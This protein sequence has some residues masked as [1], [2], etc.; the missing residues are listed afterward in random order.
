MALVGVNRYRNGGSGG[1]ERLSLSRRAFLKT[2]GAAGLFAV[3]GNGLLALWD[4]FGE[5]DLTA[6]VEAGSPAVAGVDS[7][8]IG[9]VE[10]TPTLIP[11]VCGMCPFQC[12]VIA[13]VSNGRLLKLEGNFNHSHSL[14]HICPRGSAA[15]KT[16]YDPNR[17]QTPL[18]RVGKDNFE[19]ISWEQ[20]Y[21][22]IGS[23]LQELRAQNGP[24]TLAMV[25]KPGLIDEWETQFMAAF[26]SPNIFSTSSV[27]D[28]A[29]KLACQQTLGSTPL[30]DLA[31]SKYIVMFGSNF[32]ETGYTSDTTALASAK[33]NGAHIVVVDPRLTNTAAYAHE[34]LPVKPGTEGAMMLAMMNVMVKEQLYDAAFVADYVNGFDEFTKFLED[35]TPDWAEI[36]TQLSADSITR[37]ARE[38]AG[39][40]PACAVDAGFQTSGVS[41]FNNTVQTARA[42]LALNA[43]LG[44]IGAKGGLLFP[45]SQGLGKFSP[46]S[47]APVTAQ[48]VD[49]AGSQELLFASTSD[50]VVQRLPEVIL[51]SNPYPL[52][53][54]I[55][56][57]SNPARSLPNTTKV[58]SA[59]QKLDLLVVIDTQ[60]SETAQL[61]HYVLPESTFMEREDPV[62]ASQRFVP[63]V[64]LRQPV[65]KPLYD[66]KP[67]YDI[68]T[69]LAQAAGHGDYFKFT[70]DDVNAAKL[71]PTGMQ[72]TDL[73]DTPVLRLAGPVASGGTQIA[74]PNGKVEL[75]L[76]D[77]PKAGAH[78]LPDYESPAEG[79]GNGHFR[80]LQGVD[81]AHTGTSTLNN[82]FLHYLSPENALWMNPLRALGLGI[83]DGDRVLVRSEVGEV[84][85][86]VKITQGIYP[87]AVFLAHGFGVGSKW[88]QLAYNRGVNDRVVIV[89]RVEPIAG[90]AAMGETLVKIKRIA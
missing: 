67:A 12:G 3:T 73:R 56:N 42:A 82:A 10:D 22:E 81:R 58:M 30:L 50:G 88:Q 64:A 47:T 36:E 6:T 80:M 31:N 35:K 68:I 69:G 29:V 40:K 15:A 78:P 19:K 37:I 38:L 17:L 85:V 55:V 32:A 4:R 83:S 66:T 44:N 48:R 60:M 52:R 16:L 1:M 24:E 65:V 75:Y 77:F 43:L 51:S 71:A 53:A 26:G 62:I 8:H 11:T 13:Y 54:L 33:E 70:L 89:D 21:K 87:D 7:L 28:A 18:K 61:A 9:A 41:T 76:N 63:E 14:G 46:P 79:A 25:R 49:G 57:H 34:W 20:A 45:A 74:T 84:P 2:L 72:M 86:K 90:S 5:A 59:L 39:A 27:N 23:K